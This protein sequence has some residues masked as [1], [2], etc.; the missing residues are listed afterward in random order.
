MM[1]EVTAFTKRFPCEKEKF[2]F[3]S[4][5]FLSIVL[6]QAKEINPMMIQ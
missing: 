2:M 5:G 4:K 1:Q 3:Q 6:S